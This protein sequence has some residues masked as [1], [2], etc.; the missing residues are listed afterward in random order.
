MR[1][2]FLSV[3][4]VIRLGGEA[5]AVVEHKIATVVLANNVVLP[6]TAEVT[7]VSFNNEEQEV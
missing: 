3:G 4:D 2:Q 6:R 1:A 5:V 7:V